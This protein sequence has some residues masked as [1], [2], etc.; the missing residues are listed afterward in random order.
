MTTTRLTRRTKAP[1][2]AVCRARVDAREVQ[3]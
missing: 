1:R 2:D 3:R